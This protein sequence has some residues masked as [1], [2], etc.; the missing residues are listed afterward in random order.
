[1]F[2]VRADHRRAVMVVAPHDHGMESETVFD[3]VLGAF[4]TNPS[5]HR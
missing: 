4:N 3:E 5:S 2:S 1:M